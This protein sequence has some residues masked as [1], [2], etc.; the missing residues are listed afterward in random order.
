MEYYLRLEIIHYLKLSM[1]YFLW[2]IVCNYFRTVLSECLFK[3]VKYLRTNTQ[4]QLSDPLF[5]AEL[6]LLV[7]DHNILK[8]NKKR[9]VF[10]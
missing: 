9:I 4:G 10:N 5:Q 2:L 8:R 7:I 3:L 6:W 1:E